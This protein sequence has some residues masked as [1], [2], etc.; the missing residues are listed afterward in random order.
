TSARAAL[1]VLARAVGGGRA[2]DADVRPIAGAAG[3]VGVQLAG[4]AHAAATAGSAA[5][6]I[7]LVAVARVVGAR[8]ADLH[9]RV[10]RASV[11]QG[12]A[13]AGVRTSVAGRIRRIVVAPAESVDP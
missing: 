3:A 8:R 1:R 9:A 11:G 5:V 2:F 7:G 12:G 10:V 4:L 6:D 13:I